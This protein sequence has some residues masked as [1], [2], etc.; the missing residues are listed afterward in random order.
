MIQKTQN[1][2]LSRAR[3]LKIKAL[4]IDLLV[5]GVDD[6]RI[7]NLVAHKYQVTKVFVAKLIKLIYQNWCDNGEQE[8]NIKR[9]RAILARKNLIRAGWANGN[10]ELVLR[11]EDSLT[12]IEG[13]RFDEMLITDNDINFNINFKHSKK[14]V[15]TVKDYED[16]LENPGSFEKRQEKQLKK[17]VAEFG[18]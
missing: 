10:F 7:K 14:E 1:K 8:M 11:A 5:R 3:K 9:Q 17:F 6:M 18:E 4:V 13:T 16:E 15:D 2:K 12:G